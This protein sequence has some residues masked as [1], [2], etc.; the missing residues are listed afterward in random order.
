MKAVEGF[1]VINAP[2]IEK[3]PKFLKKPNV[4]NA[5]HTL[6]GKDT[7]LN[8]DTHFAAPIVLLFGKKICLIQK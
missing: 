8:I 4:F 5:A 6:K 3:L 7:S 2:V 1:A